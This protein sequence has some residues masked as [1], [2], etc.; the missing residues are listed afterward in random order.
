MGDLGYVVTFDQTDPLYV[1][2]LSDPDQP[3]LAGQV[4]LSGYSS[5]LQ[6]LGAGLLLG[7]G[8]SVDRQLRTQGLQVEVFNVADP[9][10]PSLVSRQQL[11]DGAGTAAE[12][13]PHA[14]LWW[15]QGNLVV[16]PVDDYAGLGPSSVA[17]VWTVSSSGTLDQVGSLSQ[18]GGEG[19][20]YP[21]IERAVVVGSDIYT[22]S[23][24]GVMVND[25]ASLSPVAWLG[26]PNGS[27]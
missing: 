17:D 11:G 20:G 22:L 19:S 16:M 10:V 4:S 5:L 9:S 6:P 14:L 8:Q 27:P 7:V 1:L 21:Q 12:Y 3:V 25:T 26:Y 24:Q 2:D 23:E 13:D 15:P 18:P